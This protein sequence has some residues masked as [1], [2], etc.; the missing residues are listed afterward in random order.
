M[1]QMSERPLKIAAIVP[2]A[3]GSGRMGTPKQLLDVNGRPMLMAIVSALLDGGVTQITVVVNAQMEPRLAGLLPKHVRVVCNADRASEMIDSVR[4]GMDAE[5]GAAA[6]TGYLV[7]PCD[8]AGIAAADVRRCVESFAE[9]PDRIV[10]AKYAGK[11]GHP[12]IFP[13]SL[14]G[15]VRSSEC[16]VGLNQLARNRPDL[17][18]EVACESPGT[19]ANINTP[20]DYERM[21]RT[22]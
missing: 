12:T 7:C 21:I 15:A 2:A 5:S 13:A 4:L 11:R 16:D 18:R 9:V 20:A 6:P 17:V 19:I 14:A 1:A 10:V 3:G 8:A 22:E